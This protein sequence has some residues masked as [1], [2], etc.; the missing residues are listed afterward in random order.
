MRAIFFCKK[1]KILLSNIGNKKKNSEAKQKLVE[2]FDQRYDDAD[3]LE[4]SFYALCTEFHGS[5]RKYQLVQKMKFL[6][7]TSFLNEDSKERPRRLHV[8]FTKKKH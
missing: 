2:L 3:F 1:N 6:R 4:K 8:I 7:W 5:E